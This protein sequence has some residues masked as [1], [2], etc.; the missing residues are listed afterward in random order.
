MGGNWI[1]KGNAQLKNIIKK[2]KINTYNG[3]SL[4]TELMKIDVWRYAQ[5]SQF[6]KKLPQPLRNFED[7]RPLEQ[8]C[9][10]EKSKNNISRLYKIQ[11]IGD[12]SDVP[13]Y[14]KK[15]EIEAHNVINTLWVKF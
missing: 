14:I 5:L 2:G 3:L 1:K 7:Y 10:R 4:D 12:E 13:P 6:V 15:W 11:M 9:L 8:L